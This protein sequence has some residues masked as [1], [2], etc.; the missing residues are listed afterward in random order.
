MNATAD[1]DLPYTTFRIAL[2]SGIL[3]AVGATL[4]WLG[5]LTVR[6]WSR[7]LLVTVLVGGALGAAIHWFRHYFQVS[8]REHLGAP[9]AGA[10]NHPPVRA[11]ARAALYWAGG[12]GFLGLATEHLVAHMTAEFLVP[13]LASLAAL[14]PAGVI[15]GWSMSRGRDDDN[16]VLLVANGMFT[17]AGIA[18][19]TGAIWTLGFGSAPWFALLAWWGMLGIGMR[20]ATPAGVNAVRPLA[21]VA[22][23]AGVFVAVQLLNLLP[24]TTASYEKFGAPGNFVLE[25][26]TLAAGIEASPALP[27]TFWLDAE[28]RFQRQH[29]GPVDPPPATDS[30]GVAVRSWLVIVLFALGVGIAPRLERSLRPADYPNSETLRRDIALAAVT[31]LA[32]VGACVAARLSRGS[33]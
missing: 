13:F 18:V 17:G 8:K 33:G 25:V 19:V 10:A 16:V 9:Q 5:W 29:A 1:A 26:R 3:G 11:P 24:G 20:F 27:A 30:R 2:A 21:P 12:F 32:V 23:V 22:A 6:V 7:D 14:L 15:L 31:A 4:G 28:A